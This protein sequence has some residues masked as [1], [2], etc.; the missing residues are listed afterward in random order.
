LYRFGDK[1]PDFFSVLVTTDCRN[2]LKGAIR[3]VLVQKFKEATEKGEAMS[4]QA[5]P[6]YGSHRR[7][8][9]KQLRLLNTGEA[10][11]R[12]LVLQ[13]NG[14]AAGRP[15]EVATLSIDVMSWDPMLQCVV[16]IWPQLKT[17][18]QKLIAVSAGADRLICPL[19]AFATAF[20]MGIFKE[21]IFDEEFLN[22][23]FPE[24]AESSSVSTVITNWLKAMI[25]GS[26]NVAY[27]L[28]QVASLAKGACAAGQRVGSINEMAVGGVSAEFMACL[29]GHDLESLSTLWHYINAVLAMLIPGVRVLTGWPSLPYGHLGEGA[30]PASLDALCATGVM[31]KEKLGPL[32]DKLLNLREGFSSPQLLEDGA[33]RPFA[34][35]MAATLIMYYEESYDALEV[36]TVKDHMIAVMIDLKFVQRLCALDAHKMLINWGKTIKVRFCCHYIFCFPFL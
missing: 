2:W 11:K 31:G 7:D 20:A 17:H 22:Y 10:A 16:A 1:H 4:A 30:K 6:I 21:Q 5:P 26:T 24:L 25:P 15:G 12:A 34:R 28:N 23:L 8:I 36:P 3:Q 19:N 27:S 29:T 32:V 35:A 13:I 33:L 18:K 9:M 14:V